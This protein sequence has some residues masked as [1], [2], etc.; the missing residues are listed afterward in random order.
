MKNDMSEK[1]IKQEEHIAEDKAEAVDESGNHAKSKKQKHK[2]EDKEHEL[3]LQINELNDKY[4]RLFAEFDNFRKRAIRERTE[5]SKY[6]G[7]EIILSL[8][9]V[10]DDFDRAIKSFGSTTDLDAMREGINLI[11]NKFRSILESRGLQAID[12]TGKEFCTDFHEAITN[13]P[14]PGDDMKG[15]VVDEIEKGY[16]LNGKVIRFSKVVVGS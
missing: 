16:M 15:K 10:I 3:K 13:I 7:E 4:L 14:A 9:P 1:E 2:K 5:L 6:A 11:S 12:S 8:L